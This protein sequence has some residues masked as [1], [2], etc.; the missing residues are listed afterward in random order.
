MNGRGGKRKQGV[1]FFFLEKGRTPK[2]TI[3]VTTMRYFDRTRNRTRGIATPSASRCCGRVTSTRR[4]RRSRVNHYTI[5]PRIFQPV[6]FPNLAPHVEKK[7]FFFSKKNRPTRPVIYLPSYMKFF[8]FFWVG[9]G[10]KI[11]FFFK[12]NH[13]FK[14]LLRQRGNL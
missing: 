11:F 12:K 7:F 1:F 10:G 4:W 5:R 14:L 8:F 9:L 2:I 13:W 3:I 6:R